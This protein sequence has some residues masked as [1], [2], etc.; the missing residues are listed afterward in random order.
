M[1]HP[2][3]LCGKWDQGATGLT[4]RAMAAAPPPTVRVAMRIPVSGGRL[5]RLGHLGPGLKA[6][7]FERQPSQGLPPGFDQVEVSGI[8]RLEDKMPARVG[9]L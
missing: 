5:D 1:V 3:S 2:A 6:A 8:G 4:A 7:A 9:Q